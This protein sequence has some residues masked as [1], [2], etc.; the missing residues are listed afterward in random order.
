[1]A[2]SEILFKVKTEVLRQQSTSIDRKVKN[3]KRRFDDMQRIINASSAYWEG[4]ACN[5]HMSSYME[6]QDEIFEIIARLEEHVTDIEK[7]A[8]IY[9]E[10]EHKV[11]DIIEDLPKDVII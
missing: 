5:I 9:E 2:D 4:E 1:M 11:K 10:A 3:I 6:F 8:G 7:M